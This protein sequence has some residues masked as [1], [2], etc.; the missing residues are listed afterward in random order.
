MTAAAVTGLLVL[1]PP[2]HRVQCPVRQGDDVEGID[3][4]RR[5]RQDHGVDG[6]VSVRHV[7]RAERDPLLPP[8]RLLVQKPCHVNEMTAWQEVDD[9]M[10]LDVADRRGVLGLS[11]PTEPHEAG[12][13]QPDRPGLGQPFAVRRQQRGTVAGDR[14]VDRVPVAGQFGGDLRHGPAA[15]D[16]HGR[17]LRRP[18]RQ[19]AALRRD[20]MITQHPAPPRAAWVRAAHPV[21]APRQVHRR[22]EHR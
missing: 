16:L 21:L 22:A 1:H 8:R 20:P 3:D 2:A 14:V 18:G 17:P 7:Q 12:L 13:V 10:V 15:A 9:L 19:Q 6:R 5:L 11:V 4:L